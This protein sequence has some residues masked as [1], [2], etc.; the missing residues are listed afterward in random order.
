MATSRSTRSNYTLTPNRQY[1][2]LLATAIGMCIVVVLLYD[3]PLRGW[4]GMYER[5]FPSSVSRYVCLPTSFRTLFTANQASH[6]CIRRFLTTTAPKHVTHVR[7]AQLFA[8]SAYVLA[9][10]AYLSICAYGFWGQ[11]IPILELRLPHAH[12]N[13]RT[14]TDSTCSTSSM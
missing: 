13:L 11:F 12:V 4:T 2:V 5:Q 1:S 14:Y 8:T 3:L 7:S 9:N 6:Q 10:F